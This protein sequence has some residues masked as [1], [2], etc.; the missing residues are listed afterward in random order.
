MLLWSRVAWCT[1]ISQSQ[2]VKGRGHSV[3]DI[4][5]QREKRYN[6]GTDKL[7][8]VKLGENY[9]RAKHN[10]LHGTAFKV[11]RS[12]NLNRNSAED[13]SIAFKFET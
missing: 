3:T 13:C 10:T 7:S 8:K 2:Q 9:L 12:N 11:I 1:T 4:T 6:S 5:Y